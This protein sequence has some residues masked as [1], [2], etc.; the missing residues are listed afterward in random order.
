[1][2]T[3]AAQSSISTPRPALPTALS[4]SWRVDAETSHARFTA[5]TLAGL[6]NVPGRFRSLAG[7]LSIGE[8]DGR[9]V[10]KLGAASIDTGNRLRDRHLRSPD[11]LGAAKH[12]ELRYEA[13]SLAVDGTAIRID[14]ELLVAGTRGRLPLRAELRLHDDDAIEITCRTELDRI[15]LGVR[16][17]RGIVPRMVEVEIAV[18]LRRV[19]S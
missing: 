13:D 18:M 8:H 9:G 10:L 19:D 3:E 14:G 7:S 11:F 15:A 2:Q 4:G 17:A 5:G 16:G 12:P 1:M 6:I